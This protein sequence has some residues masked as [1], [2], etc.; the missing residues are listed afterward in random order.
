MTSPEL[1]LSSYAAFLDSKYGEGKWGREE[2][3]DDNI[4]EFR[5]RKQKGDTERSH[6]YKETILDIYRSELYYNGLRLVDDDELSA[7]I[8][9]CARTAK[10]FQ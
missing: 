2:L 4:L 1:S 6:E 8:A 9:W 3:S 10:S 5:L 7:K